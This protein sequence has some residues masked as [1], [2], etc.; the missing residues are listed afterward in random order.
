M[1]DPNLL[2]KDLRGREARELKHPAAQAS[3]P[4]YSVPAASQLGERLQSLQEHEVTLW[5][6]IVRW[7]MKPEAAPPPRV[8]ITKVEPPAS[9]S[10]KRARAI[11]QAEAPLGKPGAALT[12]KP[13]SAKPMRARG[14]EPITPTD[15]SAKAPDVPIGVVLDV[16]L[17]PVESRLASGSGEGYGWRLAA[18]A[19]VAL[20]LVAIAYGVIASLVV[21]ERAEVSD[22]KRQA[23]IFAGEVAAAQS[24]LKELELAARKMRALRELLAVRPSWLAFFTRLEELTVTSVSFSGLAVNEAG[25]VSFTAAAPSA[26]DLARQL[27]AFEEANDVVALVAMGGVTMTEATDRVSGSASAAFK[28]ELADSAVRLADQVTQP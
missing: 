23:E 11:G 13:Q 12:P 20:I 19:G 15:A 21:R 10:P 1:A 9:T 22:I 24:E 16:N 8:T 7:F 28:L 17:L 4:R 14:D 6:R 18:I 27:K 5:Q 3:P 2:P 26:T 25:E